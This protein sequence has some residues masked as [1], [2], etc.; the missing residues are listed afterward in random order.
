M[1]HWATRGQH[2]YLTFLVGDEMFGIG[3]LNVREILEYGHVTSVPMMPPF[4][5]G[6]IN[7]RG[8]V[9]PVI[10]L[11]ARF[12][13]E[14]ATIRRRTCIVICELEHEGEEQALGVVV[15]AVSE[16][17][18]IPAGEVEPPPAFGARIRNDFISGMGKVDGKFVILLELQNVL[19]VEE[20]AMLAT[21]A[22]DSA[23]KGGAYARWPGDECNWRSVSM[24]S[25]SFSA[26]WPRSPASICRRRRRS[27]SPAGWRSAFMP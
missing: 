9:V 15:D 26:G 22:E 8:S 4:V 19:A 5:R 10:D 3:I 21:M 24:P 27:W 2:Q 6:V 18:D 1:R 20:M 23:G 11:A 13:R 25:A 17:L 16:V 14:P 7:L 12:G